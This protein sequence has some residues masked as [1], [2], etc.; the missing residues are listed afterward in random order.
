LKHD[1][2]TVFGRGEIT[3]N[4][5]LVGVE[6]APAYC[7]GKVLLGVVRYFPIADHVSLG[8][9]GLFAL[10]FVPNGLAGLYGGSNPTGLMAFARI[11]LN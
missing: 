11:K 2:W 3:D 1:A 5:E 10:N 4:R 8:A 9:G 6:N 7:V